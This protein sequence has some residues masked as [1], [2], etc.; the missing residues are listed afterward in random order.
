MVRNCAVFKARGS[1]SQNSSTRLKLWQDRKIH[2]E[3]L[4]S[5]KEEDENYGSDEEEQSSEEEEFGLSRKMMK[6]EEED[7]RSNNETLEK[8]LEI[9]QTKTAAAV[10]TT[11][12]K[13]LQRI[14]TPPIY[15]MGRPSPPSVQPSSQKPLHAPSLSGAW[16]HAP[17]FV[18]LT[19][20][21]IRFY[22]SSLVQPSH[23]SGHPPLHVPPIA[24]KQQPS[25]LSNL[26]SSANL[27]NSANLY[28]STNLSVDPLQPFF[29][30]NEADQYHNRLGIK[31]GESSA[32]FGYGQPYTDLPMYSKNPVISLSNVPS[33]YITNSVAFS[34]QS[35]THDNGKP[36]LVCE[37]C[38]KQRHIKDQCWKLH[39]RP[40][41]G[42][43]R[44]SNEQQNLRRTD[45][46]ENASTSQSIGATASKT[47]SPTLSAIAQS[48]H[49]TGFSKHFVTYTP[50]AGN[51]KIWI[52][53]G[54]LASIAGKGQIVLYDG[55]SLQNVL[56]VPKLFYNLLSISKITHELHCKATFLPESVCFQDL[57]SERT[58]G[59][60]RHSRGIYILNDDTSGSNISTTSLLSSYFS[61]S[62]HDFML[63]HFRLGHPNITYMKYLFPHLFLKIDVSSLSC[64]V[65]IRAKQHRVSFPSQPYKPTQPFTLIHSDVWGPSKVTTSSGK[66]WFVTYIDDHTRLIWVYLITDKFEGIVH[67]NLCAYTPQQNGVAARKNRHLLEV[68]RSH[69]LSTS[70]PSYLWRD[71]IL[72]AAHLINRMSSRILHL[73]TPLECLKESYPSTRLVSEVPLRVFGCTAYVHSFGLNQ[74]KF[75]PWAQAYVFVGYPPYQRGYKCFHPPT[76]KYFVTMD[77]IFCEDRP[78]F[79]VSHLQGE[80]V[81]EES[82]ST[83]EFIEPTPNTVSDIDPHPIILTYKPSSLENILKEE[84][85]KGKPCTNNTMSKNDRS[86]AAVLENME[87]KNR[88]DETDVRI[89]TSND[90]AEQGHTRKHD[91]YDPSLDLPIAPRK[92]TRSV[93]YP[94]DTSPWDAKWVFTLKYKADG[95]FDRDKI[96]TLKDTLGTTSDTSIPMYSKNP[97]TSFPTLSSPYVAN[98]VPQSIA[99][100]FSGDKLNDNNYFSWSQSVKMVLE[101]QHKFNFL[102]GEIP[103]PPP[104]DP[105]ERCWKAEDFILRSILINSMEP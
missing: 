12:E 39:S 101:G 11:M 72:T 32:P 102:T 16:A 61:T 89:E 58:I 103:R 95:T 25:K 86:D 48:D 78:Y 59:T 85:Q 84:S 31:A 5:H 64:D 98:I 47:N 100:S 66:R 2:N 105:Q 91:E 43:K 74:T 19:V 41:R 17:L 26:Y 40:P 69:M 52:A 15:P 42:N 44:S 22:A 34:A 87:E 18:N 45:S 67:Q 76:R 36:I 3:N 53:D 24:A 65:C 23:P 71:A 13:L 68:A 90:E 7:E 10:D 46:R 62:E 54:S 94:K 8:I 49:L 1:I 60:A 35:L 63:W 51:E 4:D 14:Q 75:T 81:S 6:G 33:N 99:Y 77:V 37:Y 88:G 83:F 82:N 55:F 80:S 57:N 28:S 20:H 93:P 21:P 79:S 92:G 50:C 70:L 73:Q 56:H 30:R 29:Y 97:V 27:Y 96:V 38:K 104:G 9:T